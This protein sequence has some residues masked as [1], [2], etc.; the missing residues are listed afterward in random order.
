VPSDQR[1]V[2]LNVAM[3]CLLDELG[4]LQRPALQDA[5]VMV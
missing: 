4:I 1:L 5:I 3:L 2:R